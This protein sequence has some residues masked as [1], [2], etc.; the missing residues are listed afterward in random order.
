MEQPVRT[1]PSRVVDLRVHSLRR[2][3]ADLARVV[4]GALGS[5]T[6]RVLVMN[7]GG[8]R[9]M[10]ALSHGFLLDPLA[11][12]PAV[13]VRG[14]FQHA[15]LSH[16]PTAEYVRRLHRAGAALRTTG[17]LPVRMVVVDDLVLVTASTQPAT[18]VQVIRSAPVAGLAAALFEECWRPAD[19]AGDARAPGPGGRPDA[20][21]S[22]LE[23]SVLHLLAEGHKDETAARMLNT[24]IRSL[25][26]VVAVLLDRLD[27]TTRFQAGVRAE[28]W[29]WIK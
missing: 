22:G 12:P 28:Q 18:E 13:P 15:V 24:S 2:D 5:A 25:R 26:R 23:L 1:G 10:S 8:G 27:S 9:T 7:P 20:P 19:E 6:H 16:R 4:D 21:L 11:L 29:G 14:L 3:S 17:V